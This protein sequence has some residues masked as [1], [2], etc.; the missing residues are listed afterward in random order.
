MVKKDDK[1]VLDTTEQQMEKRPEFDYY[2]KGTGAG[3]LLQTK[4]LQKL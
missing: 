4:V 2:R 1:M 3:L